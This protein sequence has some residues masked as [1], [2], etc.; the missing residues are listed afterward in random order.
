M[1]WMFLI[2]IFWGSTLFAQVTFEAET[3]IE[4]GSELFERY[5]NFRESV[6]KL[7]PPLQADTDQQEEVFSEKR[8]DPVGQ[9][10]EWWLQQSG[11][12]MSHSGGTASLSPALQSRIWEKGD[13]RE[14]MIWEHPGR[15][16]FYATL[17]G[18]DSLPTEEIAWSKTAD[19]EQRKGETLEEF[20]NREIN[21][22][23]VAWVFPSPYTPDQIAPVFPP[24]M[25]MSQG[26]GAEFRVDWTFA[27]DEK[28]P[29]GVQVDFGP[30][31][32]SGPF[33]VW[34][35]TTGDLTAS[36][37][38]PGHWAP[39]VWQGDRPTESVWDT[40]LSFATLPTPTFLRAT[41]GVVDSDI[42][43]MDD[44]FELWF[45]G[46][47]AEPG[48]GDSDQDGI[49]N[50]QEFLAGTDPTTVDVSGDGTLHASRYLSGLSLETTS[51]SQGTLQV[52]SPLE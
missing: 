33:T 28:T 7:N 50:H 9:L 38:L 37:G 14:L 34:Y 21:T 39:V 42:D 23:R 51:H 6:W 26:T 18:T 48:N 12:F 16:K 47:L 19:W 45:F 41:L 40:P 11:W 27:T 52:L 22:R 24:M 5:V 36:S 44:G 3:Q 13:V 46:D 8:S 29:N 17:L 15:G 43:L 31:T 35:H 32:A 30:E 20:H 1:R 25:M 4:T 49:L 10:W 2:G